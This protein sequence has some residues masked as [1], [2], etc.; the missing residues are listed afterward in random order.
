MESTSEKDRTIPNFKPD[1]IMRDNEKGMRV[2]I[3][4]AIAGDRYVIKTEDTNI[5]KYKY[6]T[7]ER[8]LVCKVKK[9]R[10]Q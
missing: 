10:Y 6:L 5:L 7:V 9:K 8:E 1:I 3:N 4:T 2:L